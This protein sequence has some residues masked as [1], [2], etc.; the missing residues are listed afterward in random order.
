MESQ[1]HSFVN[2]SFD[3]SWT[4]KIM[5]QMFHPGES[6]PPVPIK[7]KTKYFAPFNNSGRDLQ[8]SET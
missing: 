1:L 4:D 7:C 5:S 3:K 2:S 6:T 8:I